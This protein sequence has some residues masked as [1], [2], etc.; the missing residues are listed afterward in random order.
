MVDVDAHMDLPKDIVTFF[1]SQ[2][3]KVG[4]AE[5]AFVSSGAIANPLCFGK[6]GK[7]CLVL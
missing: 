7:Q 1:W 5:V 3:P 6:V 2:T 4:E